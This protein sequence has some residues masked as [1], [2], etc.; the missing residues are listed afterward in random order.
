MDRNLYFHH[1]QISVCLIVYLCFNFHKTHSTKLN[2]R[3]EDERWSD[4]QSSRKCCAT[5]C[6]LYIYG[7]NTL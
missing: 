1:I 3:E 2:I 4:S 5:K 7:V 6:T